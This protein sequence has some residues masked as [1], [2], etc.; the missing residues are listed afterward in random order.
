MHCRDEL[1]EMMLRRIRRTQATA[2][3]Q[4]DAL[5]DQH[6]AIEENLIGIFGQVM[7]TEQAQDTDA[8][9][10]RHVRK[11]LAEQ[12]GVSALAEQYKTVSAWHHGNELPL[13]WP[14]HARHRALLFRLLDL[15]NV[16]SATQD[17]SLL[18]ALAIVSG[19]RHARRDEVLGEIDLGFASQRWQG[20]VA[21]GANLALSI[22]GRLRSAYSSTWPTP[23]KPATSTLSAPRPS[24]TIVPSSYLGQNAKHGCRPTVPLSVFLNE[25]KILP[26]R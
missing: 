2:K 12:G 11:L 20:F 15:M 19:H 7:E 14:I 9:F 6:R 18:D 5:H 8:I 17:R 23:C 4:L 3:E 25:G 24:L 26:P 21:P 22:G 10:G 16:Q 13:L 1:I